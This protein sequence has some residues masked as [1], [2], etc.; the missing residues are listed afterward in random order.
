MTVLRRYQVRGV[1]FIQKHDGRAY[2]GDDQGLGKTVQIIKYRDWFCRKGRMVVVP[3]AYLKWNWEEEFA[4]HSPG[5]YTQVLS[6]RK[7]PPDFGRGVPPNAVL[8][9]NYEVLPYWARALK[10]LKPVLLVSDES[11]YLGNPDSGRT[12]AFRKLAEGVPHLV[13]ASGTPATN[14]PIELWPALSMMHPDEWGTYRAFGFKYC[15]PEWTPWGWKFPGS[16]NEKKLRKKLKRLGFIRRTKEQ[17]LKDLPPKER[18]LIPVELSNYAEYKAAEAGVARWL[19][20]NKGKK[21]KTVDRRAKIT[22][23]RML[24]GKLKVKAA[25]QWVKD[26][27]HGKG[28]ALVF[29]SH[30]AVVRGLQERFKDVSVLVDGGVTKEKR[31]TAFKRVINDPTCR[32]LFANIRAANTGWS[33]TGVSTVCFVEFDWTPGAHAQAEDRTRGINRGVAGVPTTAY[34]LYAKDTVDEM[35]LKVQEKK[36]KSL[37]AIFD[38]EEKVEDE[39]TLDLLEQLIIEKHSRRK[40]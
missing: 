22:E 26:F 14:R 35:M 38:G 18:I 12:R 16:S 27:L 11:H 3:P 25:E 24:V 36:R 23:L 32:L 7:V 33:A 13:F 4:K 20:A 30:V 19:R 21:G 39:S 40:K 15:G 29:C 6:S 37:A 8:I 9:V 17:V 28:K 1:Q 31:K 5:T 2:L 34:Y 10:Q